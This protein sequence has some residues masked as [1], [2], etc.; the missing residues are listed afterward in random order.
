[1]LFLLAFECG[2]GPLFFVIASEMFEAPKLKSVGLAYCNVA[3]WILNIVVTLAF[4][5]LSAL[6]L[7]VQWLNTYWVLAIVATLSFVYLLIFLPETS[8]AKTVAPFDERE[9]GSSPGLDKER[10]LLLAEERSEALG[11]V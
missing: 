3:G 5:K 9:D 10:N 11:D 2:P 7:E 8:G 6:S 4:P 1:M